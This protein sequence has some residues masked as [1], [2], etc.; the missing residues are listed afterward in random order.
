[1]AK[2][3]YFR[4]GKRAL[5]SGESMTL[6]LWGVASGKEV[7]AYSGRSKLYTG[8]FTP[9]GKRVLSCTNDKAL[10]LWDV[11]SGAELRRF[12]GH[13][14]P[15]STALVLP[16]GKRALSY[17]VQDK[18]IRVW[19]LATAK[20]ESK[21]DLGDNL[22]DMTA[23]ALSPDGK[24][25]LAGYQGKPVLRQ[26]GVRLEP[27]PNVRL[28][29][30]ASGKEIHRFDCADQPAR[31]VVFARRSLRGEW[32]LAGFGLSLADAG[33]VSEDCRRTGRRA[34]QWASRRPGTRRRRFEMGRAHAATAV[35]DRLRKGPGRGQGQT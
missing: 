25:I 35:C 15:A 16:D 30:L 26:G 29:E 11:E 22:S 23:V 34:D 28:I 6:R 20:E 14:E 12:E 1:M 2:P 32:Q 9:D 17:S 31:P 8:V 10:C 7:Q 3:R 24:R 4:D 27:T 5:S 33:Y 19:E 13:A 18:S 21:L